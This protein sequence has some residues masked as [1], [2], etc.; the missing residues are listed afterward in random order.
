MASSYTIFTG[1]YAGE[2][3]SKIAYLEEL[4]TTKEKDAA[5]NVFYYLVQTFSRMT[6]MV[7]SAS[8]IDYC[9]VDGIN[10]FQEG[11]FLL[12]FYGV[13]RDLASEEKQEMQR[14]LRD[15]CQLRVFYN[16]RQRSRQNFRGKHLKGALCIQVSRPDAGLATSTTTS[17]SASASM[18]ST[19]Y[20][21][22]IVESMKEKYMDCFRTPTVSMKSTPRQ[23]AR[24]RLAETSFLK[25][26]MLYALGV[27]NEED[28]LES[29][30]ARDEDPDLPS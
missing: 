30:L 24:T 16:D 8:M 28:V 12:T 23:R 25:R 17:L 14:H 7:S 2:R 27:Q 1:P 10:D 29:G 22:A 3:V 26:C 19:P 5:S 21:P 11:V 4:K 6:S 13:R 18:S 20:N 9:E 15:F